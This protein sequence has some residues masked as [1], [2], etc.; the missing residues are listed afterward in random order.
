MFSLR[1]AGLPMAPG[2]SA[3]SPSAWPPSPPPLTPEGSP[4]MDRGPVSEAHLLG[5]GFR[6]SAPSSIL[7]PRSDRC[8][9]QGSPG[10]PPPPSTPPGRAPRPR[11]PGP[12]SCLLADRQTDR[13]V[14]LS[15]DRRGARRSA[16]TFSSLRF[17]KHAHLNGP[18]LG[19]I[20]WSFRSVPSQ[21]WLS[22]YI[23]QTR[24]EDGPFSPSGRTPL[25]PGGG[26]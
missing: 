11:L 19:A 21:R 20:V 8:R 1:L 9:T 16:R 13:Q 14:L 2:A 17:Y 25:V 5:V 4:L 7:C 6:P 10:T 23:K 3:S 15:A 18:C 12:W 24:K 26:E 22:F